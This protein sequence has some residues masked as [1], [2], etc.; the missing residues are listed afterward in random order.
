MPANISSN[1]LIFSKTSQTISS[2]TSPAINCTSDCTL[3]KQFI[4]IK[5]FIS[6]NFRVNVSVYEI[7]RINS[8]G[9]KITLETKAVKAVAFAPTSA[10]SPCDCCTAQFT[11]TAPGKDNE[12]ILLA[13]SARDLFQAPATKAIQVVLNT[14]QPESSS[15]GE[16]RSILCI[17]TSHALFLKGQDAIAISFLALPAA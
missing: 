6:L 8:S 3:L 11:G 9:I 12:P 10:V 7:H 15:S 1:K 2:V 13:S 4:F 16:N 17:S 14:L 5:G